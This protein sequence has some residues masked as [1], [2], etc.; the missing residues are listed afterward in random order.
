MEMIKV[1]SSNIESVGWLNGELYIAFNSGTTYVYFDV[2]EKVFKD[3]LDAPSQG[4]FFHANI[5][6]KYDYDKA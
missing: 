3:M 5:R 6:G 2:P 4:K 1:E